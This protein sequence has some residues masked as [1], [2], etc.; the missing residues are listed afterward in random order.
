MSNV[1]NDISISFSKGHTPTPTTPGITS[2]P[3][4]PSVFV[5]PSSSGTQQ[6]VTQNV[7]GHYNYQLRSEDH[8]TSPPTIVTQTI[9]TDNRRF[10]PQEH[11]KGTVSSVTLVFQNRFPE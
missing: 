2:R 11:V 1:L 5:S 4:S 10:F 7:M 3:H 8:V 9:L 6:G